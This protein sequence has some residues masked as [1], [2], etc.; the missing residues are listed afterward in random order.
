MSDLNNPYRPSSPMK[1]ASASTGPTK[2]PH[3]GLGITGFILSLISAI[4]MVETFVSAGVVAVNNPELVDEAAVTMML[5]G[6]A[7][8]GFGFLS[9]LALGLSFGSLFQRTRKKLFGI[10][11]IVI[12]G[13]LILGTG[14]L[15]LLG[16]IAG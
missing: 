10:M 2:V 13:M 6:L 3:S 4:G 15:M 8:I 16:A 5:V 11:G 12:S 9:L 14:G 7:V 1:S